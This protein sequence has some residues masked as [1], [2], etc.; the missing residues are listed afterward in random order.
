MPFRP[1]PAP[2]VARRA[3][4]IAAALVLLLA[5]TP[6]APV[7]TAAAST[8]TASV[9]TELL[10]LTN[11]DRAAIGLRPLRHD[12]RLA[13]I[14]RVRATTLTTAASF[15]HSAA[16]GSLVPALAAADVQW[17]MAG[18][19][20]A[21]MP[22]G[23]TGATAALIFREW[24]E[25]PAHF[26]LLMSNRL[27]YVGF[28]AAL[29]GLDGRVF[30]SAVFTESAD[31]SAPSARVGTATRSGTAIAFT[32]RGYDAPLQ[33]H[34]AG[35]RDFDVRYRVDAGAWR[36]LRDN[37]TATALRLG[38]RTRGHRYWVSVRARDRAGNIGGWSPAVSIWVP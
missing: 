13:E 25:S 18:E 24:K 34:W 28:G 6:V 35:L 30:A 12:A 31:H 1:G 15:S 27:N 23:L 9:A 10:R 17:Y 7:P 26:E 19:D 5:G 2:A 16:G 37:T 11:A 33:T 38:S 22:G 20:L 36:L 4:V 32:W 14:A 3:A 29:R 8:T 21:W